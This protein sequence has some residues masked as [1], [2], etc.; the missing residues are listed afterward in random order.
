MQKRYLE[1]GKIVSTHGL[2]GELRVQ[3]WCDGPGFL[4]EFSSFY[5]DSGTTSVE[6]EGARAH[7]NMLI[8]KLKGVDCI[9]TG[10]AMRG[11][12][13]YIDRED[14]PPMEE[15]EHFIQDLLGLRALDADTGREYGRITDVL[16]TGANDVYELTG[17]Q[18][19][20]K[21]VPAIPDVIIEIDLEGGVMRIRPL[22]GLFDDA[23]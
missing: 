2:R 6:V 14:A 5:L 21:L 1:C 22:K 23:H 18:R 8:L 16:H 7:K 4:L 3:P 19:E 13:L 11:K 17:E 20:K 9:D 15:G 12:I 10:A